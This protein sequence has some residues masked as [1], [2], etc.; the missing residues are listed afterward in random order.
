MD[1]KQAI[2]QLK[3]GDIRALSTLIDN[4]QVRAIRTAYLITQDAALAEDV[5]QNTFVSV[6]RSIHT[7][8]LERPFAPWFMRSV[9]NSAVKAV[10]VFDKHTSLDAPDDEADFTPTEPLID[11]ALQPDQ[12]I[13]TAETESLIW[14]MLG[15][16]SAVQRAVI[17]LRFY[18]DL[19]ETE[20]AQHLNIPV[21]TVKSR[22]HNAKRQLY[23]LLA[24]HLERG[25][26]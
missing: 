7:F 10:Q 5:V 20:I 6:Y 15:Q 21:G 11:V 3:R 2:Q 23:S 14:Q 9:V 18:L 24:N 4:Y 13:E 22:L 19:S 16:I 25:E 17:V 12:I 26:L 1:D 8:D